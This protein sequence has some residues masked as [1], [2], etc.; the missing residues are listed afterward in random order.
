MSRLEV[1][2]HCLDDLGADHDVGLDGVIFALTATGPGAVVSSGVRGGTALHV[3][4][5]DLT[6]LAAG[7]V[8]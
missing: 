1:I 2:G 4:N 7:V 6:K 5:A 3:D 8:R